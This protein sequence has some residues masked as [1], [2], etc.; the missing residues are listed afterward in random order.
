[1]EASNGRLC[2]ERL[3]KHRFS[4]LCVP[5]RTIEAWRTDYNTMHP[6]GSPGGMALAKFTRCPRQGHENTEANSSPA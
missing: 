5:R 6:H 2:E 3:N 4:S 1:M